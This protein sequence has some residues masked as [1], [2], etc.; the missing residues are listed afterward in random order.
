MN[1]SRRLFAKRPFQGARVFILVVLSLSLFIYDR[2]LDSFIKLRTQFFPVI[3]APFQR[4]VNWPSYLVQA[5]SKNLLNK[6][7]LSD[8][9]N[10]LRSELLLSQVELQRLEFLEREN[11]QLRALLNVTKKLGTKFLV[12]SIS[13]IDKQIII[14]KGKADG[15]YIGQPMLD[16]YGL[17]GQV[18]SI[19]EKVSKVLSI[20]DDKSAIPATVVRN[21]IQIIVVGMGNNSNLEL[22]N[23]PETTDIEEGDFLVTSN[24]GKHFPAGYAIGSVRKINHIPGERFMKVLVTPSAHVHSSENVVLVWN[25]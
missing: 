18:I 5:V 25:N 24:A 13:G 14:D 21:G 4:L 23:I 12:A 20:I 9:N 10:Y 17:F 1:S 19:G 8:E 22:V 6:N 3:A 11:S 2:H 16:A 15:L 7:M